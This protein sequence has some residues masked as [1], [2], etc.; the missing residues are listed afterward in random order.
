LTPTFIEPRVEFRGL[1]EA[2]ISKALND[3][4]ATNPIVAEVVQLMAGYA[5]N[6]S[7]GARWPIEAVALRLMKEATTDASNWPDLS[8]KPEAIIKRARKPR[9]RRRKV[10]ALKAQRDSW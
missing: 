1:T 6:L 2:E 8:M 4:A 10:R 5:A 3:P 9:N 7:L